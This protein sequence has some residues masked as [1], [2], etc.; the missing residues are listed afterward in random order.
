MDHLPHSQ[1]NV[2]HSLKRSCTSSSS[3]EGDSTSH[4]STSLQEDFSDDLL[5]LSVSCGFSWNSASNPQMGL[6][7]EKWIPGAKLC[8]HKVLLGHILDREV[9]RVETRTRQQ[10]KGKILTGQCDGWK[11][12]AKTSV[13]ISMITVEHAVSFANNDSI[14]ILLITCRPIL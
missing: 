4:W 1:P 8:D 7:V 5:K 6:F 10:I 13:I 14:T 9:A 2:T 3:F 12:V 11:N